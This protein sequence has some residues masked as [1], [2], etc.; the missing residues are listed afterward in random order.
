MTSAEI[1]KLAPSFI[2]ISP[3]PSSPDEAGISVELIRDAYKNSI[4]LLE[5]T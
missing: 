1:I 4:P 3:G 2:V 5:S